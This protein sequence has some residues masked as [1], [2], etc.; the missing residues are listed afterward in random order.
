MCL[1]TKAFIPCAIAQTLTTFIIPGS[2]AE[3]HTLFIQKYH[4]SASYTFLSYF[5]NNAVV[6]FRIRDKLHIAL[7]FTPFMQYPFC[8][9]ICIS[10]ETFPCI[11]IKTPGCAYET[12]CGAYEY[13][14]MID[15]DR[16]RYYGYRNTPHTWLHIIR[17]WC[18]ILTQME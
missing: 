10:F 9:I 15:F 1:A 14:I 11:F 2:D 12:I 6:Q 7:H 13:R 18:I 3:K 8:I 17:R 16:N 5:M 4:V